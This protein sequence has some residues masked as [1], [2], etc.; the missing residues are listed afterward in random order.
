M[1]IGFILA[2]IPY[3]SIFRLVF[4]IYLMAPQTDGASVIYNS[5]LKKFL[6]DHEKDIQNFVEQVQA[7]AT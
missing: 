6:K 2:F 4:I 3:Y 7:K 5:F 1:F